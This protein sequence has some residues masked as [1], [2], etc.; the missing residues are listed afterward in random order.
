[1]PNFARR[2]VLSLSLPMLGVSF[3]R[4]FGT[5]GFSSMKAANALAVLAAALF[6]A[7]CQYAPDMLDRTVAYNRA[8]ADSTNQVLLLNIV[9]A[10]QRLPTYYSRLEGDASS[11]GLTPSAGLNVPLSN[12]RSFENDLNTG[13]AGA[14][15]SGTS[16]A[17][18]SL[19][20]LAGSFGLQASESNL[21]T[22]QTLDDQKY[23][24]GMMTPVPL[25]NIQSF[26]DEGYQ[27][28]LLFMMFLSSVQISGRLMEP[29]EA[30]ATTRCNQVRRG[31]DDHAGGIS[32]TRQACAYIDSRPYQRLFDPAGTHPA[33]YSFSLKTC[34]DTGG[35]VQDDPPD[36][37]V[38]FNNDPARGGRRETAQ[39]P[40]PGVCFQILLNDLLILGLKVGS[41]QDVPAELVDAVPDAVA[42]NPQF[43][44]QILQQNMFVRQ[45][46]NDV[47]AICRKKAQDNGFTLTFANP[48]APSAA[49]APTLTT[50]LTQLGVTD[51]K[52]PPNAPAAP[53][54]ASNFASAATGYPADPLAACQ[55]KKVGAPESA[56]DRV[57]G[58]TESDTDPRTS[59]EPAPVKLSADKIAF[60]TR[61][62]EGMIYYLGE[63]LRHEED[64]DADP[65]TFPRVLGRNPALSGGDYYEVMFYGSSHLGGGDTAVSVRD[66]SGTTYAVPKSCMTDSSSQASGRVACSSE[67]P[68][69]ESLPLMNFVNQVW[70]LQKESVQGPTSPLVVVSPQ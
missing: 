35:A 18:T 37:M 54:S 5:W 17:I 29:I 22:L 19:A 55:Q 33:A 40:H 57:L 41:T 60:S 10:S 14:V 26:Q 16:K 34:L 8:V 65:L 61:S 21:L 31:L 20:A 25:K 69:N 58:A 50:L 49:T 59:G 12:Q 52:S 62:F 7:A 56:Q 3:L 15:T 36:D 38:H 44:A 27:R 53:P 66:D 70:G 51:Q 68:D 42:Q 9:R 4:A 64:K 13:A 39:D 67:Y 23:Q 24:N 2:A 28:D 6:C 1:M 46:A 11:L 48:M 32:F 45:A 30:A 63:T 43:R 47:S